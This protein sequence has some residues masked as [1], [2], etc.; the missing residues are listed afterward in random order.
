MAAVLTNQAPV[1]KGFHVTKLL[2]GNA[3]RTARFSGACS[4]QARILR[5]LIARHGPSH[6]NYTCLTHSRLFDVEPHAEHGNI[7][8]PSESRIEICANAPF[9]TISIGDEEENSSLSKKQLPRLGTTV[10]PEG[11]T[12]RSTTRP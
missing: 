10:A 8:A 4:R 2:I 3:I 7:L 11:T 6:C 1:G 9:Q 12:V 5:V